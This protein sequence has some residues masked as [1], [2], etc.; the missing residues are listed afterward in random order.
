[1]HQKTLAI[2]SKWM[3]LGGIESGPR[4]FTGGLDPAYLEDHDKEDIAALKSTMFVIPEASDEEKWEVDFESIARCFLSTEFT[5]FFDW[6]TKQQVQECTNIMRNFYNYLLHHNVCPEYRDQLLAAR[7]I[8]DQADVELPKMKQ[9]SRL[10]PGDFNT[11]CSTLH[12][13]SFAG[14]YAGENTWGGATDLGYSERDARAIVMAGI[15]ALSSEQQYEIAQSKLSAGFKTISEEH[16]GLEVILVEYADTET[17]E[18]YEQ[19]KLK[20]VFLRTLGRLHCKR[21]TPPHAPRE[22]LP[23]SV[24]E[25]AK[26]DTFVLWVEEYILEYC[27]VGMKM[28]AVVMELDIGVKWIDAVQTTHPSFHMSL[29]NERIR[30]WK[31]PGPPRSWMER[32]GEG[33]NDQAVLADAG[34]AGATAQGGDENGAA[35]DDVN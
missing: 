15:A 22:D 3:I 7:K 4:Q 29:I 26:P 27:A 9:A 21:W 14:L 8:C 11:A 1:M 25:K 17:K 28:E 33:D 18:L 23:A 12:N 13:G 10:L 16:V 35:E 34:F 19:S 30:D 24:R 2:F 6:E 32:Q 20:D 5:T 31:E